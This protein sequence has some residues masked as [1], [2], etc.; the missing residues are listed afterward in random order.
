MKG[1]GSFFVAV[2]L[3]IGVPCCFAIVVDGP[4]HGPRVVGVIVAFILGIVGLICHAAGKPDARAI[5]KQELRTGKAKKC[6]FCAETIK[7]EAK[8]C[9][10]CGRDVPSSQLTTVATETPLTAPAS[11]SEQPRGAA[12]RHE[13]AP[14]AFIEGFDR[15]TA[16][17]SVARSSAGRAIHDRSVANDVRQR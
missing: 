16:N 9:R 11:V 6:P 4:G 10:F 15:G 13:H 2:A 17:F 7:T 14:S 8:V 1:L 5:E 3:L 12:L